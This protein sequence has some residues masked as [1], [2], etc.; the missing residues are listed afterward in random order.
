M[1]EDSAMYKA[2]EFI[3]LALQ[4]QPGLF[5]T[6]PLHDAQKAKQAA[7]SLAALRAELTAQLTPQQ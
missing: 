1:K 7:Q 3:K 2:D 4:Y 5:G 6:A